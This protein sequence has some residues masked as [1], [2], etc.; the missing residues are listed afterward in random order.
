MNTYEDDFVNNVLSSIPRQAT[1]DLDLEFFKRIVTAASGSYLSEKDAE[2]IYFKC[3]K[4]IDAGWGSD[5]DN[6]MWILLSNML[7]KQLLL[8][9]L[10]RSL[11]SGINLLATAPPF[12]MTASTAIIPSTLRSNSA[13]NLTAAD[14]VKRKRLSNTISGHLSSTSVSSLSNNK[15]KKLKIKKAN[16]NAVSLSNTVH[17]NITRKFDELATKYSQ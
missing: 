9:Y 6:S 14:D 7:R 11:S 3:L 15:S 1:I 17:G 4:L 16:T 2:M 12:M 5:L 10:A 13:L 8:S